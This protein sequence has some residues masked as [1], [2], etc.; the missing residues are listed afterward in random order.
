MPK[1]PSAPTRFTSEFKMAYSQL[2]A[3]KAGADQIAGG[4]QIVIGQREHDALGSIANPYTGFC[5][6]HELA[7]IIFN[8]I[9]AR[10]GP[11]ILISATDAGP[12]EGNRLLGLRLEVVLYYSLEA[13]NVGKIGNV[14][15]QH[16]AFR[17]GNRN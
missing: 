4:W 2:D 15:G 9:D 16:G 7:T 14:A 11:L 3:E 1:S 8:F 13:V 5:S 10:P 12:D 17:R 6:T